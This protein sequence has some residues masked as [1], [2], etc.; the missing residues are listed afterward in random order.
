MAVVI[1]PEEDHVRQEMAQVQGGC[2]GI[3]AGIEAC[4]ARLEQRVECI[5]ITAEKLT[6]AYGLFFILFRG[7][8][9]ASMKRV[10]VM[11]E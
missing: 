7:R 3:Y 8:A 5:A 10:R 2:G 11:S 6:L 1:E 9:A 4:G